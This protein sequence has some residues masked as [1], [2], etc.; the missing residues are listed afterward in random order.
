MPLTTRSE[1]TLTDKPP[2]TPRRAS[3]MD[4]PARDVLIVDDDDAIRNLIHAAL[5]RSG[6]TCDISADGLEALD[7]L[8][9]NMYAVMLLDLMMP[10]L[11]GPGVLTRLR[12]AGPDGERPVV[13]VVTAS[14]D[15]ESLNP[16]AEMV[17]VVI[18][19]PFDLT[20]L[21]ELVQD[22]VAA[23]KRETISD[24]SATFRARL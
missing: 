24:Q 21:S 9:A 19:K 12:A 8:Q 16:V 10:R 13:V 23:R 3:K 18:R 5:T 20:R 11:D 7:Q 14:T 1:R 22:C 4:R 6:L 17:Q 15:R 2:Q